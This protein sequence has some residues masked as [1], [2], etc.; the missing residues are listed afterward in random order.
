MAMRESK[1]FFERLGWAWAGGPFLAPARDAV[2]LGASDADFLDVRVGS[3][4]CPGGVKRPASG[5]F[6]TLSDAVIGCLVWSPALG[7]C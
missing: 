4:G 2:L 6:W 7:E 3:R 1:R 5:R